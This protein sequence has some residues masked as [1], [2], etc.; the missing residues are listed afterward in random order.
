VVRLVAPPVTEQG[1][2]N[3]DSS[4]GESEHG[5]RM[6]FAGNVD[7]VSV[8]TD[9]GN[10]AFANPPI[11]A[12]ETPPTGAGWSCFPSSIPSENFALG[13]AGQL[14]HCRVC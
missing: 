1:P 2:Q 3:V 9:K 7:K 12:L 5:L 6:P 13:E 4:A 10:A 8:H 11:T 14:L